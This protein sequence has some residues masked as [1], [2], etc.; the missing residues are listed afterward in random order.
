MDIF[1]SKLLVCSRVIS[2]YRR[3]NLPF[4]R[5]RNERENIPKYPR[6]ID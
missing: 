6:K 5:S 3:V 1:K 4:P 2:E